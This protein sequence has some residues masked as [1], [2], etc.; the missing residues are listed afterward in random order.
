MITF[1]EAVPDD[2][3][4]MA[5][6]LR[7]PDRMEAERMGGAVEPQIRDGIERSRLAVLF[8][9]DDAP[10]CLMGIVEPYVLRPDVGSP[11]LLGT[12]A[13]DR[14]KKAFL[15]DTR[16]WLDEIREPYSLLF[17]YVDAEYTGA[18]RWLR[19]LGFAVHAPVRIG[20]QH[21]LFCRFEMR[22]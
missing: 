17:N 15:R 7:A 6:L 12:P 4:L 20:V 21:K 1:R 18:I 8:L 22:L 9:A 19:W 2:A 11:W 14:H 3:A 10:L 5:P 16:R 13:L